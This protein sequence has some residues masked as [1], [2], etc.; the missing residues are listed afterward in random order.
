MEATRARKSRRT[1]ISRVRIARP[2][3]TESDYAFRYTIIPTMLGQ[4][5]ERSSPFPYPSRPSA[6]G[7]RRE[8]LTPKGMPDTVGVTCPL[9]PASRL[10]RARRRH[11]DHPRYECPHLSTIGPIY[12]TVYRPNHRHPPAIG[13]QLTR[14]CVTQRSQENQRW[15]TA[16]SGT[17]RP[18][19]APDLRTLATCADSGRSKL[20]RKVRCSSEVCPGEQ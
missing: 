17:C 3:E 14:R 11:E 19:G 1:S 7:F 4:G 16:R 2:L 10:S 12:G 5:P 13:S 20:L 8:Y 18:G 6:T 9:S 15:R